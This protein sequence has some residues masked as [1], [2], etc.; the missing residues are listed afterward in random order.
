[1]LLPNLI[2]LGAQR[3]GTTWLHDQLAAHPQVYVP[4]RRKEIH[5]FDRYFDR[6]LNWYSN[7]FPD[8]AAGC[9]WVGEITPAYLYH[10]G[11]P[12]RIAATLPDCRFLVILRQPAKRAYS[13][14]GLLVRSANECRPFR[15]YL[16]EEPDGFA[17]GL[18]A[19]QLTRYFAVF[20]RTRFLILIFEEL[21]ADMPAALGTIA[22]FLGI[23]AREF[24]PGTNGRGK[25]NRSYQPRFG[26]VYASAHRLGEWL[27][28]HE[29]DPVV[30]F[31]KAAGLPKLFGNRGGLPELDSG[32]LLRMTEK[33]RPD[34]QKLERMLGRD[35]SIWYEKQDLNQG[36]AT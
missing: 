30:N 1:M 3:A 16:S 18:Y 36:K 35:L 21:M 26:R 7:F 14:Y 11:S 29:L 22:S 5:F 17:R 32:T 15:Q 6:G 4:A 33:Y 9:K 2:G 25:V 34:I 12:A 23:D 20:S 31:A 27:R 24:I 28:R 8:E 19:R 13:Q 10:P